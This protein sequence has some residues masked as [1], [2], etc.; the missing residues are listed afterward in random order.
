MAEAKSDEFDDIDDLC[1]R[2]IGTFCADV[3]QKANSG[4]PGAPMGMAAI[5]HILWTKIL[6][7][8]PEDSSYIN[9]D[10]FVLSNGHACALQYT[11]L[12]LSGYKVK[13]EDLKE[14]RQLNSITPGHPENV[15]TDGVELST[16]PLG[17]GIAQAVGQAIAAKYAQ[18]MFPDLFNNNI[19]VFCGDGCMQEGVASEAASLAGHLQL[20]NLI[21]IYDDNN[22]QIDGG[23]DLAFTENV[24]K[25]FEAYNWNVLYVKDGNK[26]L[27]AIYDAIQKGK[28]SDDK[29][30][31]IC[32]K[33]KIGF[34]S[35]KEASEKAHGSPLGDEVLK[36]YKTKMGFN[37]DEK[38]IIKQEVYQRYKDSF[39]KRGKEQQDKFNKLKDE[40]CKKFPEKAKLLNRLLE[41]K[42]PEKWQEA[43]PKYDENS[44]VEASRNTNG[45]ILNEIVKVIPEIIGGAADLTPSTKTLLKC[46]HDF[47]GTIYL[48]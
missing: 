40:Y 27:K 38:F 17:Q 1:I 44:K 18:S 33:T 11:M 29:P 12:H 28:N 32:I 21:L 36:D 34:G 13:M 43:L 25:R 19:Y 24:G 7:A 22:I 47:Q 30:T 2:N 9:R 4:H 10:R 26:D 35:K 46:S 14:F 48:I 3:V 15:L 37:P 20:N 6:N 23:T 31:L 16:G 42:L 5:A 39:I 45:A 8:N 41:G